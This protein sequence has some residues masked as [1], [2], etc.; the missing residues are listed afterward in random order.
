[1]VVTFLGRCRFKSVRIPSPTRT[2]DFM[3]RFIAPDWDRTSEPPLSP[4]S[5][6]LP[7]RPQAQNYL[8]ANISGAPL[9][10]QILPDT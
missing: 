6:A 5:S 8:I 3:K 2:C 4:M 9:S 7:P 1:M 10:I